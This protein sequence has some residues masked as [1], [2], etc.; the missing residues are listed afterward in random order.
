M[1]KSKIFIVVSC[2]ILSLASCDISIVALNGY[3]S[4]ESTSV[5]N[6]T[7]DELTSEVS[8]SENSST[9]QT[10]EEEISSNEVSSS[11][12]VSSSKETSSEEESS[13]S[14][15]ITSDPYTD[16]DVDEFYENYTVASSYMDSYYRSLH[17]LMSGIIDDQIGDP[18]ISDNQPMDGSLYVRNITEN[19]IYDT[20]GDAIGYNIVDYK[21]DVVDTIYK[22]GGYVNLEEV[23]A[24][25]YAF[26]EKTANHITSNKEYNILSSSWGEYCRGNFS[27]FSCDTVKYPDEPDLPDNYGGS[28]GD[29]NKKYYELDI[30]TTGT[31]T[32]DGYEVG[33]YNDGDDVIRGAARM[34]FTYNYSTDSHIEDSEERFV[35]YTYNHY[36][37]FQEYLNYW[38]GWGEMFG[39]R[40]SN[41]DEY[42]ET[43]NQVF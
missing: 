13:S 41:S 34:V 27:Y 9:E 21:G 33:D 39:T 37:D 32:G 42:P 36:Y 14:T 5:S 3:S 19:Y 23:S 29:N 24:Y 20:D 1:K 30:G 7:S 10:S 31:D 38:G 2:G 25:T 17:S 12:E 22:G 18:I 43:S 35:F 6:S 28:I 15:E 40:N 8:S 16:V 11:E 4:S 26:G